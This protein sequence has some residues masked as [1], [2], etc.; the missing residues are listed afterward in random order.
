MM[1]AVAVMYAKCYGVTRS[2][3]KPPLGLPPP[4]DWDRGSQRELNFT[5]ALKGE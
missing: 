2:E 5:W 4:P 1:K 3:R